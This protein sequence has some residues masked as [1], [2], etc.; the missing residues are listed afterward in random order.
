MGRTCS[1]LGR[2]EKCIQDFWSENLKGSDYLEEL[3]T[4]ERI[5]LE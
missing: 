5:I 2:D 3:C 4:D 1:K